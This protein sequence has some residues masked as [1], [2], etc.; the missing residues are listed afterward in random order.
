MCYHSSVATQPNVAVFFK[1]SIQVAL[2]NGH[3]VK[4]VGHYRVWLGCDTTGCP[5]VF[6]SRKRLNNMVYWM[7]IFAIVFMFMVKVPFYWCAVIV[8]M[9]FGI[10]GAQSEHKWSPGLYLLPMVS[11]WVAIIMVVGKILFW[12]FS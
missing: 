1:L 8:L 2:I 4:T 5:F 9:I 11:I 3:L 10:A 7:V 6:Y 12:I